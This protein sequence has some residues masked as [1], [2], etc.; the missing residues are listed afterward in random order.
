MVEQNNSSKKAVLGFKESEIDLLQRMFKDA[1]V[2]MCLLRGPDHRIIYINNKFREL[3]G[4]RSFP[5]GTPAREAWPELKGQDSGGMDIFDRMDHIYK[6][7]EPFVVNENEVFIDRTNSGKLDRGYFNFVYQPLKDDQGKVYSLFI[8]GQEVTGRVKA[9]KAKGRAE[10]RFQIALEGAKLGFWE[11]D[12][13][14]G[15]FTFLSDQ[16]KMHLGRSPKETVTYEEFYEAL[17]PDDIN[18]V[19]DK[20]KEAVDESVLYEV[21]Y[22]VIWPDD[23][24]HW[25][26]VRGY[27][28]V[29]EE[30]APERRIG[31]II[32]I[33]H[34]KETEQRLKEAVRARDDF[35]SVASHELQTP[36]T[37]IKTRAQLLQMRLENNGEKGYSAE[38]AKITEQIEQLSRLSDNLLDISRIR[39]GKLKLEKEIFAMG[40]LVDETI[41]NFKDLSHHSIVVNGSAE[42]KVYADKYRI[43][44]VLTNLLSNAI[45]YSREAD[46]IIIDV[47]QEGEDVFVS[48]TDFGIGISE[49]DQEKIFNRFYRGSDDIKNTY[50]GMGIG[51]YISAEIIE[52]H[53][54]A[55]KVESNKDQGAVFTFALSAAKP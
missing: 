11:V 55:I 46:K 47:W 42:Q 49:S 30:G 7:G 9:R 29:D 40:D 26:L 22:R 53:N 33:T 52:R 2:F 37:S 10:K 25:L 8:T 28:I 6:T 17:H 50:P 3:Y 1:P 4:N 48:V 21:E 15:I 13:K 35:L 23:S 39:E 44:Q 41:D 12:V 19:Q 18:H 38:A 20:A 31:I 51:L 5:I 27:S 54:G 34:H 45:K 16:A 14:R 43:G 24:L 36:I 32:D